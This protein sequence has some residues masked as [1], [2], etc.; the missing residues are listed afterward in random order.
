MNISTN[1]LVRLG[2]KP[3]TKLSIINNLTHIYLFDINASNVTLPFYKYN[4][5]SN[6]SKNV[7]YL[8]GC[9]NSRAFVFFK[10]D[11]NIHIYQEDG[12]NEYRSITRS[13]TILICIE[14]RI[15]F[16]I[17]SA[18]YILTALVVKTPEK[19]FV[20]FST[21]F[22]SLTEDVDYKGVNKLSMYY[23]VNWPR[24]ADKN[25]INDDINTFRHG[26]SEKLKIVKHILGDKLIRFNTITNVSDLTTNTLNNIVTSAQKNALRVNRIKQR[27]SKIVKNIRKKP[28][29][30]SECNNEHT[31]MG[32]SL[33]DDVPSKNIIK[34]NDGNCEDILYFKEAAEV[35]SRAVTIN[36]YTLTDLTASEKERIISKLTDNGINFFIRN[37]KQTSIFNLFQITSETRHTGMI[38]DTATLGYFIDSD[39]GNFIA[40]RGKY[41]VYEND[42]L[43][44]VVNNWDQ[45]SRNLTD[46]DSNVL[47]NL[48]INYNS[49]TYMF[50]FQIKELTIIEYE[51]YNQHLE[52]IQ[53]QKTRELRNTKHY[54]FI[55]KSNKS[56]KY[57]K[58][59]KSKKYKKS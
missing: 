51:N 16:R 34:L 15:R 57:K 19:Y 12:K 54:N 53:R 25:R 24:N 11:N 44:G 21:P 50:E 22:L 43:K 28:T 2:F 17:G 8:Y 42:I 49:D 37:G 32:Y 6:V 56:K 29:L 10:R 23:S 40:I 59:K 47:M 1:E 39:T 35:S 36:P 5:L 27:I 20:L 52:D 41:G 38:E 46:I 4:C 7:K 48:P 55:K 26:Y 58:S 33:K 30:F 3:S 31:L 14:T 45:S 18:T 13:Y 9:L